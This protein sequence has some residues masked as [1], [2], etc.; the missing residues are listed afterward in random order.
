MRVYRSLPDVGPKEFRTPYA[1]IG[2]FDG[3]HKGHRHLFEE[4]RAWAG[5]ARDVVAIT[6]RD[7]PLSVLGRMSPAIISSL[8]HRLL[9]LERI[10]VDATVVLDFDRRMAAWS[11]EEF[12]EEVLRRRLGSRHLLMGYDAAFGRGAEGTAASLE[13]NPKLSW[14]EVRSARPFLI[15]GHAVSS[16]EVR[17]AILKG[18][19][20]RAAILLGR[21]PSLYGEVIHGDGRGRSLGFPTANLN[22]F[23]SAAPPHGVYIAGAVLVAGGPGE[24]AGSERQPIGSLVNIGRRPTF[25]G[26][27]VPLDYSRY[28]NEQLDKVEIYLHDFEGDLYGRRLEA[29][30]YKKIRDERRFA[31]SEE[32]VRQIERDRDALL[33]WQ[34][35]EGSARPR[36]KS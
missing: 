25:L 9:L 26:P 17:S 1:T 28:F 21:Q 34:S 22:L 20:D 16:T 6:F 3:V 11:A 19:L 5:S 23:H 12:V 27:D 24:A 14:L 7:H 33:A 15:D 31:D 4:L 32:L 30:L 2:V 36:D 8:D 29:V 35:H 13:A 18:D 10:G